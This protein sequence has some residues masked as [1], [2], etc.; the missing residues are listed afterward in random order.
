MTF[1]GSAAEEGGT[2]G[3][4]I[5]A[6]ARMMLR[7]CTVNPGG[8]VHT[9]PVQWTDGGNICESGRDRDDVVFLPGCGDQPGGQWRWLGLGMRHK[10]GRVNLQTRD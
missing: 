3:M 10:Y 4:A 5:A 2:A 6:V 7:F 1:R 9:M 8:I